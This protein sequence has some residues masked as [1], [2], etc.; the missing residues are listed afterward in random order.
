MTTWKDSLMRRDEVKAAFEEG[1][2]TGFGD[3][4]EG[5]EPAMADRWEKSAARKQLCEKPLAG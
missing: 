3:R 1:Y 5:R 4:T 2:K